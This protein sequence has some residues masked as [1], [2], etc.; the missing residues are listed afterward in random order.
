MSDNIWYVSSTPF[1][2]FAQLSRLIKI[3][4]IKFHYDDI[5]RTVPQDNILDDY[6]IENIFK[7]LS[8]KNEKSILDDNCF[9][10]DEEIKWL[11]F[12]D[13][14]K[15][16]Y[17]I[18]KKKLVATEL[19][20][21]CCHPLILD[22][23]RKICNNE[24]ILSRVQEKLIN[25]HQRRIEE[26]QTKIDNLLVGSLGYH[27]T[28]SSYQNVVSESTYILSILKKLVANDEDESKCTIC[29]DNYNKVTMTKCGHLFCNLCIMNWFKSNKNC[30]ICKVH[31]EITDL[32]IKKKDNTE[33]RKYGTKISSLIDIIND[34]IKTKTNKIIIFSQ[35][36]NMLNLIGDILNSAN[37]KNKSI[38]GNVNI[39]AANINEFKNSDNY[40]VIMLSMKNCASGTNLNNAT[41]VI[42]TDIID[43]SKEYI[44]SVESQALGR[45]CRLGQKNKI[46]L[47][48]LLIK[49]TIEE[50]IFNKCYN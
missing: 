31:N 38:K 13:I 27:L 45:A 28:K 6:I 41:H 37:I 5:E 26:Y 10:Y 7:A 18:K 33:H 30:P 42:F 8:I 15:D 17:D 48:R 3:N 34:I 12:N 43:G 44:K 14:E 35:W 9:K 2:N 40:N 49:D 25:H 24:V 46:K 39:R 36:D 21:L 11:E 50:T 22:S 23:Y 47:I 4:D 20:Q 32:I 16:L 1:S 19:Q 29:F